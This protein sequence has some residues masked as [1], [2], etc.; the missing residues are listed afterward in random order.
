MLEYMVIGY[1]ILFAIGV[2]VANYV[3]IIKRINQRRKFMNDK[4]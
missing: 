4:K 3:S 1:V 2:V